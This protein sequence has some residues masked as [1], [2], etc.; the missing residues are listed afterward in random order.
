MPNPPLGNPAPSPGPWNGAPPLTNP[1][2]GPIMPNPPLGNPV[3]DQPPNN[4]AF[5]CQYGDASFATAAE[6]GQHMMTVHN[7][8]NTLGTPAVSPVPYNPTVAPVLSNLVNTQSL[9][10]RVLAN[11]AAIRA[12]RNLL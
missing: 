6:L 12:R 4:M 3:P 10:D 9:R 11:I 2:P 7:Q 1:N 8:G 5:P